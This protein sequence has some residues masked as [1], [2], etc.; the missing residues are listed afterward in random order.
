MINFREYQKEYIR[1]ISK[2]F[3]DGF[4]KICVV[5]PCGSGKTA[6]FAGMADASQKNDKCVWFLVHRKELLDQTINTFNRFGIERKTIYVGMVA[7]MANAIEKQP[8]RYPAPDFIITDEC[9]HAPSRTYQRIYDHYPNAYYVGLT[10]TPNRLDGKP[11]G[12]LYQTMIECIKV[13]ELINQGYLSPFKYYAPCVADLSALKRKGKDFD[14]KQAEEL[15][16]TRAVFGD[17]IKNYKK[18]ANDMQTICYCSSVKHSENVA[19]AF[20]QAGIT[21]VHF[22]GN[23]SKSERDRIV[24]DFRAGKI[25]ILCNVDLI[26]EGFDCPDCECCILLRPTMSLTLFIQQAMRC[27][28]PKADKTAII[29]DHVNN[30][31]RHGLPDDD[32]DWSLNGT[33]KPLKEYNSDGTLQIRQCPKCFG[34][35]RSTS[36]KKCPY[37]GAIEELTRQEIKNIKQIELEEIKES[38]RKKADEA[39]IDYRSADECKTVQELFALARKKGYKPYWAYLEAKRRRWLK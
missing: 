37:C 21:A 11:L 9:Q 31:K 10:A 32:R 33:P 28:R 2:A 8:N 4:T 27:M 13:K 35:Y 29:L 23:T 7:T 17:V 6:L 22:D 38:K 15:L 1:Q 19:K 25:K 34:T 5:A 24:D 20:K 36:T 39:V 26:S 30:Y 18:Y 12:D 16:S 14:Q 3:D